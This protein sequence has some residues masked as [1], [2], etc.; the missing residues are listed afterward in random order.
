MYKIKYAD[1]SMEE[2]VKIIPKIFHT[3]AVH[4]NLL[5]KNAKIKF[6]KLINSNLKLI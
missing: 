4:N 3:V 2:F 6:N 5:I 1:V